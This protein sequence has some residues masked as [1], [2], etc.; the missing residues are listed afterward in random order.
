MIDMCYNAVLMFY[1]VHMH[2]LLTGNV[3]GIVKIIFRKFM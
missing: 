2:I 3:V 1:T